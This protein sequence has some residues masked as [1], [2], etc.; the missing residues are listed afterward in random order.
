MNEKKN[1]VKKKKKKKE[2]KRSRNWMGY[3]LTRSRY[4]ELYRDIAVMACSLAGE[5]VMIQSIVS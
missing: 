1:D 2:K 5:R 3:C 4:N